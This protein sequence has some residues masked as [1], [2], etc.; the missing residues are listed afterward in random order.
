VTLAEPAVLSAGVAWRISDVWTVTLQGDHVSYRPVRRALAEFS[1]SP[2]LTLPDAFEP[3]AGIEATFPAPFGGYLKLRVGARRESTGRLRY[4]G[5]DPVLTQA[6]RPERA[7]FRAAVGASVF[8][9]FY[10]KGFRLDVD[11]SQ[12]LLVRS[13][14]LAAAG[15]R[16]FS[17]GLTVR[18]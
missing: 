18:L 5:T 10:D 1:A 7:L 2:V 6:F 14:S 8:G 13:L 16:R 15:T 11:T 3:R 9:E 12:V 17:V 4:D